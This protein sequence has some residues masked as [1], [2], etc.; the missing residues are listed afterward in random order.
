[1]E[2]LVHRENSPLVQTQKHR[3]GKTEPRER[4]GESPLCSATEA[5]DAACGDLPAACSGAQGLPG[6]FSVDFSFF[7]T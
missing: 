2:K 4:D 6:T 5:P 7:L 3:R 1:M